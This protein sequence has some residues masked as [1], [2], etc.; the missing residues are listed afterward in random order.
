MGRGSIEVV[1][2]VRER[3][4]G[5]NGELL[6]GDQG[7]MRRARV[8]EGVGIERPVGEGGEAGHHVVRGQADL[9][10]QP[11]GYELGLEAIDIPD[12]LGGA[13]RGSTRS[14]HCARA[15]IGWGWKG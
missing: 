3:I 11:G 10:A 15:A 2:E 9:A 6:S 12:A 5:D 4:I 8:V 7:G 1:P 14:A 13:G